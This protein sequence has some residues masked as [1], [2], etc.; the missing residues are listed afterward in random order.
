M[1]EIAALADVCS[2]FRNGRHIDTFPMAS[3]T[4]AEIVPLMIG[5]EVSRAYPSK[6]SVNSA[7]GNRLAAAQ[8]ETPAPALEVV[9]LSWEH[10]LNGIS[11]TVRKGEPLRL[12]YALYVHAGMAAAEK[13]EEQWKAFAATPWLEFPTKK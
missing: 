3:R 4:T 2:V 9:N 6:L 8:P 10:V 12:R 11:L 5:R 7:I 1:H 13:I